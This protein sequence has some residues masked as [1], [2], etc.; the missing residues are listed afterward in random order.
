VW[1]AQNDARYVVVDLSL[2][3]GGGY[4]TLRVDDVSE[5]SD[6]GGAGGIYA[7]IGK[8]RFGEV[9]DAKATPYV[10]MQFTPDGW[11][12]ALPL[13]T[14]YIAIEDEDDL[15]IRHVVVHPNEN[16]QSALQ[17]LLH[18]LTGQ[19]EPREWFAPGFIRSEDIEWDEL[20]VAL[21]GLPGSLVLWRDCV[22][23]PATPWD[24]LGPAFAALGITPRIT[25]DGKVGFARMQ[26]PGPATAE[27][28]AVDSTVWEALSASEVESS[29]DD[30]PLVNCVKV[31]HTYDY[32]TDE[33]AAPIAIHWRDGWNELQASRTVSYPCR[34]WKNDA[35][36]M[37]TAISE[38]V[39]ATHYGMWGRL[40]NSVEIPCT[41]TSR[42]LRC[43]DIVSVTHELVPDLAAGAIGVS[44]RYGV[45]VGRTTNLAGSEVDRLFVRLCPD[46]SAKG[47]APCAL[48]TSHSTGT[49][50]IWFA[51]D[52]AG[53]YYPDGD[54]V[55]F[56]SLTTPF[57]ALFHSY[58]TA[59]Y[60]E[61]SAVVSSVSSGGSGLEGVVCLHTDIFS[62]WVGDPEL[63]HLSS[64]FPTG[65][66]YFTIAKHGAS[67]AEQRAYAYIA[68]AAAV[69]VLST[70]AANEW[71]V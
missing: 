15:T 21:G 14:R 62:Q 61:W 9:Y 2:T 23:E 43:G 1:E 16:F 51:S 66:A 34:G 41:W 32:R 47:I 24:L 49:G 33:Y 7:Q 35:A 59:T 65:G 29:T 44:A 39:D 57:N 28:V 54:L 27:T 56:S 31:E 52:A 5:M 12:T 45:I 70:N 26:T 42:Q 50:R 71:T 55:L 22:T 60:A 38:Q 46:V 19:K 10:A 30:S 64:V 48:A 58:N 36:G 4:P 20:T 63:M 18:L 25:T 6:A 68:A 53:R 69:P 8:D 11:D 17:R 13:T 67:S 40:A 3:P 37:A